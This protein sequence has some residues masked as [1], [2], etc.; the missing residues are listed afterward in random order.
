VQSISWQ[1]LTVRDEAAFA[2]TTPIAS[3]H[4]AGL[5]AAS[6]VVETP[7]RCV[8]LRRKPTQ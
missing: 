8:R 2:G 5:V 1:R 3:R 7:Q 4:D 6:V